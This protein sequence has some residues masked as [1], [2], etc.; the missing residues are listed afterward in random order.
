M[1]DASDW[2]GRVGS[3]WAT[4]WRRTDRSFGALAD[5]LNTVIREL[6]PESGTALDIGCGAGATSLALATARPGLAVT[7]VDLSPPLLAAARD[8][9]A[10]LA[11]LTFVE[12]DVQSTAAKLAPIDLM[13]SRHGVMFFADPVAGFATLHAAAAPG[14]PLVF[15]CFRAP[16][17][18]RWATDI[19]AAAIGASPAPR[20]NA[21][22]PFAFADEARVAR[23][24]ADAGWSEARAEPADFVFCAGAGDDPVA[25]AVGFFSRI[26]PAAPLLRELP[27]SSR[28]AA[29]DRIARLCAAH[30][31]GG[32]VEFPAAAWLW[33]ARARGASA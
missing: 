25:D 30:L 28:E 24:L 15:T 11:N 23:I 8:R 32:I 7:G 5:R 3:T 17:L 29:L 12:G 26:G 14:A 18:N 13:V 27:P 20:D 4:E 2:T 6:A 22:G 10:G 21:P 33:T 19:A 31:R 1:T 16:G 9:A